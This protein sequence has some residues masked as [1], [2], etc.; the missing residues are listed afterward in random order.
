MSLKVLG[1][2]TS[3]RIKGNSDTLL[4]RAL[5]GAESTGA[6][7]E[8]IR[9]SDFK[10]GPCIECNACYSTGRCSVEDDYQQL[11]EKL[12]D[13]DRLIFATPIFFMTVCAQAKMLIDRC[14]CL[15]AY[16][17][18]LKKELFNP[19]RDRRALVIAV[20]GSKGVKQ[21]DSI[22]RTMKAYFDCLQM[23]YVAGLY[24]NQVDNRGDI[25]QHPS[26]LNEAFRLGSGL[27]VIGTPLPQ[28]PNDVELT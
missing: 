25:E 9:L 2:S 27:A 21:F 19:E 15:W 20:G 4:L 28:K 17:Y 11:L 7:T 6:R 8:Y 5:E 12:I 18:V 24:V 3:P 10:I 26:A 1:I 13:T 16:K 14:Q 23:N 22:R